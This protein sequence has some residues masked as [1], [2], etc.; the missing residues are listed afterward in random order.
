M[1]VITGASPNLP[2]GLLDHKKTYKETAAFRRAEELQARRNDSF[3]LKRRSASW[4]DDDPVINIAFAFSFAIIRMREGAKPTR[5]E[6]VSC[7]SRTGL[8]PQTIRS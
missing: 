1:A 7:T 6:T 8:H 2:F 3:R 4:R 5:V